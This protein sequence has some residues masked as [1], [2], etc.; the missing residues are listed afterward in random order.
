MF[1]SGALCERDCC[2]VGEQ[3]SFLLKTFQNGLHLGGLS[4]LTHHRAKW[5][6]HKRGHEETCRSRHPPGKGTTCL[7]PRGFATGGVVCV[8]GGTTCCY[9]SS[10]RAMFLLHP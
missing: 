8:S 7:T 2:S 4:S 1:H 3:V 5:D 9:A 6:P 10:A